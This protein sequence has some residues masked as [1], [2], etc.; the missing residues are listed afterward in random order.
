MVK[1]N[2]N[3]VSTSRICD[4]CIYDYFCMKVNR[5]MKSCIRYLKVE[6]GKQ[7]RTMQSNKEQNHNNSQ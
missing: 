5:P 6:D 3:K 7:A 1:K 2:N 4:T